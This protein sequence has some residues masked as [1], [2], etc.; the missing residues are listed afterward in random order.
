MLYRINQTVFARYSAVNLGVLYLIAVLLGIFVIVSKNPIVSVLFL[1][2]IATKLFLNLI[3]SYLANVS[4]NLFTKYPYF[5]K[6]V[7]RL[8]T[9]LDLFHTYLYI[10]GCNIHNVFKDNLPIIYNIAIYIYME[11]LTVVNGNVS[12]NMAV[13][14]SLYVLYDLSSINI[15]LFAL[16]LLNEESKQYFIKNIELRD[17]CPILYRIILTI[18]LLINSI[19]ILYF[20]DLIFINLIKPLLQFWTGIL[21][22]A[23][24]GGGNKDSGGLHDKGSN[25]NPKKPSST[26]FIHSDKK[27]DED[28]NIQLQ[29]KFEPFYKANE[30]FVRADAN[31]GRDWEVSCKDLFDDYAKYLPEKD[32]KRLM[33]LKTT[34]FPKFKLNREDSVHQFW[35]NK[36]SS[37]RAGWDST[38]EIINIFA[39]NSKNI[40]QQL[41]GKTSY[42]SHLFRKE[43]ERFK[44]MW[45]TPYKAKESIIKR[46]LDK[47]REFDKLLKKNNLS[48]KDLIDSVVKFQK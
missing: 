47:S 18:S 13:I 30:E 36:R 35:L 26:P 43:T 27:D 23:S 14:L 11:Y 24:P 37:N 2:A 19:I 40:Q 3:N 25:P 20:L 45:A 39:N 34:E 28:L 44:N 17:N 6:I 7:H 5:Y 15:L 8:F 12:K 1:V 22:M 33:E 10:I 42:K 29:K 48:I 4:T 38:L 9:V 31:I 46:E 32:R 41:G 16:L 21:K